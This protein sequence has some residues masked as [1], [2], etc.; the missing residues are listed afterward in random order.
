[1]DLLEILTILTGIANTLWIIWSSYK[2]N[3]P[4]VKKLE[5]EA[6]K[7]EAEVDSEM[8]NTAN[9]LGQGARTSVEILLASIV[10]LRADLDS[11][12]KARKEDNEYFRR[13]FKEA[14]REARDYRVWAAKLA[15]QVI[16]AGKIPAVFVPSPADSEQ[17]LTAIDEQKKDI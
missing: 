13:R 4:E 15:K 2:K 5:S 6:D 7:V 12:K 3:K 1:M 16:E 9:I 8:A 14:E 11:E 17:G 10:Q